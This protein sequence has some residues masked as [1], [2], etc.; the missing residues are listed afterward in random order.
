MGIVGDAFKKLFGVLWDIIQWLGKLLYKIFEPIIDFFKMILDV[1]FAIVDSIL[2]FIY[3]VGVLIAKLFI[4]LFETGKLLWSLIVGFAKT[5]A[6]LNFSPRG[7]GGNAHSEN[8]GKIFHMLEPLQLNA[9]ATILLFLIWFTTAIA[10]IK[11][12]SST[13]IGGD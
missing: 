6:S 9:V 5:L 10:A 3:Q 1:I 4:I 13:R 2:Y 8:I 11:Y 7:S 12:I